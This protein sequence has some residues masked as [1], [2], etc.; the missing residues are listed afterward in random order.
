[1]K[2]AT[3]NYALLALLVTLAM[4]SSFVA[5]CVVPTQP[6][7][8]EQ[9]SA[10][11]EA[12]AEAPP[13]EPKIFRDGALLDQ[14]LSSLDPQSEMSLAMYGVARSIYSTLVRLGY[15]GDLNVYPD[16]AESWD[17]SEDGK[18]YT[19]QLRPG[20]K[21]HTGQEVTAEDVKFTFERLYNPEL[22]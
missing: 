4:L 12:E 8:A 19:F 16:L 11:T 13:A 9:P 10:A 15:E 17:I 3:K 6:A 1:M 21:F 14:D 5:G 7:P 22:A 18:V 2:H 20:V